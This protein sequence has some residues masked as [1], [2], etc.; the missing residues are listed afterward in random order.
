MESRDRDLRGRP[1][2]A[3]PRDALGRPLP[4]DAVGEVPRVPENLDLTPAQALVL[5]Q[6]YLDAGLPFHAH[7]VFEAEW[8]TRPSEERDLWQGLA[9]LA[10]GIT[11]A[12]RGNRIGADALLRRGAE[13]LERYRGPTYGV[14]IPAVLRQ[15]TRAR[16]GL[17]TDTPPA[18]LVVVRRHSTSAE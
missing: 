5:G 15:V 13:R 14:D 10:V 18:S 17:G 2:N 4:R 7:E 16:A 12:L 8:K 1:R 6:E 3:R 9:Q 11:H